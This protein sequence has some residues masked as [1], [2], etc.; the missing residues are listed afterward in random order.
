MA[1]SKTSPA[2]YAPATAVLGIIARFRDKGL[3]VP[4]DADVMARA[5]VSD[6]LIP[7]TLQALQTLELIDDKGHPTQTLEGLRL[8]TTAEYTDKLKDWLSNVYSEV[9]QFADPATDSAIEVRDAFRGYNPAGQ[10]D[11]MV[12]LFLGLCV[13]AGITGEAKRAPPSAQTKAKSVRAPV[14]SRTRAAEEQTGDKTPPKAQVL[15]LHPALSGILTSIPDGT[16]WSK[17]ERDKF[18]AT[19]EAILDFVVPVT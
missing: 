9:F 11:R 5:G 10:Q 19:F 1:V 3:T 7:R 12:S 2:P 4:F 6:S 18:V 16:G 17:A 14:V 13:A 15:G 8:A